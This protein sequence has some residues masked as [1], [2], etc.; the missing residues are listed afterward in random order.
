MK[1]NVGS[2]DKIIR[3]IIAAVAIYA[4]YTGMVASPLNYVL[5]AVAAIMVGTALMGSCPLFSIFGIRSNKIK[6]Q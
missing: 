5:Y 1:K 3:L 4:A 2:I 6:N